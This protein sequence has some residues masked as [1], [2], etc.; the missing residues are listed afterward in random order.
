MW[1]ACP[2]LLHFVPFSVLI[3]LQGFILNNCVN[4][5]DTLLS[6]VFGGVKC[7]KIQELGLVACPAVTDMGLIGLTN[8]PQKLFEFP[9]ARVLVELVRRALLV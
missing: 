3:L 4:V 8:A 9:S 5:T 7:K 2:C 6:R 1:P